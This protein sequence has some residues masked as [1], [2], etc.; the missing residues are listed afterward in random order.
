MRSHPAAIEDEVIAQGA[1][2]IDLTPSDIGRE[3]AT[4]VDGD[5]ARSKGRGSTGTIL[6]GRV[7]TCADGDTAHV[8]PPIVMLPVKDGLAL[9][10]SPTATIQAT[11]QE[12]QRPGTRREC[13]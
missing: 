9:T 5:G 7:V 4:A 11:I 13:R 8:A 10:I 12:S 3:N 2:V 6:D 1:S